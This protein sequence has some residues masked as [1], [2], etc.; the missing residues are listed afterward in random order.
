MLNAGAA[1]II[2]AS[3]C[4]DGRPA[5]KSKRRT[6]LQSREPYTPCQQGQAQST[7][8]S[9]HAFALTCA[10]SGL[11]AVAPMRLQH[12]R[13]TRASLVQ[14]DSTA[15]AC[16]PQGQSMDVCSGVV[17]RRGGLACE[18]MTETSGDQGIR[19][20]TLAGKRGCQLGQ[21]ELTYVTANMSR[22]RK[23]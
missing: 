9:M 8:T 5:V 13:N 1:A 2:T 19:R 23:S 11:R 6:A 7:N 17:S 4:S 22:Q 12:M 10:C 15:P 14:L 16:L 18:R 21:P 3:T 20:R